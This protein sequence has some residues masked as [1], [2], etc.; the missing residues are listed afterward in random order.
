MKETMTVDGYV[1][2]LAEYAYQTSQGLVGYSKSP[3]LVLAGEVKEIPDDHEW[4]TPLTPI[5]RAPQGDTFFLE[6]ST[7]INYSRYQLEQE[8]KE[9]EWLESRR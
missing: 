2:H 3:N 4:L 7:E 9:L 6:G 5:T 8:Q 1:Y